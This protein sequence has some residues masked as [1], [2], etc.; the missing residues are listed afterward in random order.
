MVT[1]EVTWDYALIRESASCDH[2]LL[3]ALLGSAEVLLWARAATVPQL[4]NSAC[5]FARLPLGA[6]SGLWLGHL[7]FWLRVATA[8]SLQPWHRGLAANQA[9]S[10]NG[11]RAR[12]E[13]SELP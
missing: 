9:K 13:N 8:S 7:H 12:D 2:S 4:G 3:S 6:S 10:W 1:S 11:F 5:P